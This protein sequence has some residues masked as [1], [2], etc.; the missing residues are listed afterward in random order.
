[1]ETNGRFWASVQGSV[2]AGWDF[3]NW[4][5]DYFVHGKMPEPEPITP[6]GLTCWH[7]GDFLALLKFIAGKGEVPTPGTNPA[8]LHAVMQ[9][10]SGFQPGIRSDVFRWNDP[11]P[12]LIEPWPY[13]QRLARAIRCNGGSYSRAMQIMFPASPNLVDSIQPAKSFDRLS[14][15]GEKEGATPLKASSGA[16]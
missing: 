3:P 15:L 4:T 7:T 13:F 11:L 6:G 12:A 16:R 10:L 2:Y 1:M 5:F 8:R 14:A 9:F